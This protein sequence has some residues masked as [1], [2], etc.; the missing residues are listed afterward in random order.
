MGTVAVDAVAAR[1]DLRSG[2]ARWPH[3]GPASSRSVM[4]SAS[5]PLL[6]RNTIWIASAPAPEN[7]HVGGQG[8]SGT[9]Y[10]ARTVRGNGLLEASPVPGYA[11]P[12]FSGSL[13]H[14]GRP[15]L[16]SGA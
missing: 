13:S 6:R 16:S 1:K 4:M 3:I 8:G 9:I 15:R 12:D 14:A 10:F 7:Q 2:L 5:P 11:R